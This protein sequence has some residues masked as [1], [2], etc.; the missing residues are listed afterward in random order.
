MTR[1]LLY[2]ALRRLNHR[3]PPPLHLLQ[4]RMH[5]DPPGGGPFGGLRP[6]PFVPAVLPIRVRMLRRVRAVAPVLAE[7]AAARAQAGLLGRACRVVAGAEL[8]MVGVSADAA[9][10][11]GLVRI[12]GIADMNNSNDHPLCLT[13]GAGDERS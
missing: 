7:P 8:R 3:G 1:R 4:G 9:S 13:P 6:P 11:P 10:V 2:D 5:T 12:V